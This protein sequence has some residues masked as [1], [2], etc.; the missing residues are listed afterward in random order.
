MI[1]D[2]DVF[3]RWGHGWLALYAEVWLLLFLLALLVA[4]DRSKK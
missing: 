4:G 1:G 3:V 2:A